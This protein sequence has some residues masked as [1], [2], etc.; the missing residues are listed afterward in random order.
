MTNMGDTSGSARRSR[1]YLP[2]ILIVAVIV[3]V[4]VFAVIARTPTGPATNQGKVAG[5]MADV[6][7][8]AATGGGSN[9]G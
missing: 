7:N 5:A 6:H 8:P 1:R 4:G 2:A 3:I 9:G